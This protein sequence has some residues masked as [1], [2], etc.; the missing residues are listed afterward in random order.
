MAI[1]TAIKSII[2]CFK[3]DNP[4]KAVRPTAFE[5]IQNS[6]KTLEISRNGGLKMNPQ[7]IAN[8][9]EFKKKIEALQRIIK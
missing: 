1:A 2:L 6:Y 9:P 8:D 4:Y 7:E 3:S 5:L